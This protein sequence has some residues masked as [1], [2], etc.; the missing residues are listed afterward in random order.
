MGRR[1]IRTAVLVLLVALL[2]VLVAGCENKAE[3][4]VNLTR[5]DSGVPQTLYVG[6]VVHIRLPANPSTGYMWAVD[7]TLPYSLEQTSDAVYETTSSAIGAGGIETWTLRVKAQVDGKLR[8]KYW[9]SFEPSAPVDTIF[10]MPFS[11]K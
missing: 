8:L 11:V 6:Q 7:G 4:P 5:Q 1:A 3:K 10:D 9:R 2:G